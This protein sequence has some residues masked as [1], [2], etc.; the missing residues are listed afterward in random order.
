MKVDTSNLTKKT[1]FVMS[2]NIFGGITGY[3]TLFFIFRLVGRGAWGILGA[4]TAFIGLLTIFSDFGISATHVKK[5][6]EE[7]DV[8]EKMGTYVFIKILYS[9]IFLLISFLA[10]YLAGV[11]GFKFESIYLKEAV[12][13]T[14]LY[15]FLSSIVGIF[16]TSLRAEMKI[17]QAII[18]DFFRTIVQ[19]IALIGI[20]VWWVYNP[21][22]EKGY[23]GVLYTYGYLI[24]VFVQLI[25]LITYC[26]GYKFKKPSIRTIKSYMFF[27]IPLSLLGAVGIIQGYTDRAMLQFFWNYYEVGSYFG[28]QKIVFAVM[29]F[30]TA[31]IFVLYP[32]QTHHFSWKDR[33]K[34]ARITYD[35]ERYISLFILPLIGFGIVFSPEIL[36]IWNKSLISY[37]LVFQIL[38]IYSYLYVM[39]V[40]YSSQ[41]VSAGKP[42]E[43]LKAGVLQATLNVF[44]NAILI[45]SSIFGITLLGLKSVGAAVATCTS[46]LIGFSIIRY[47]AYKVLGTKFNKRIFLHFIAV[48]ISSFILYFIQIYIYHFIKF[49]ELLLA[50]GIFLGIYIGILNI[51]G[52]LKKDELLMI[53][54][55]FLV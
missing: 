51:T 24:G 25:L 26:R 38:L 29:T 42:K 13:I 39:N 7:G 28:I 47:R 35:A 1:A 31:V 46:Y 43:N 41:L 48:I 12:I 55:K 19:D 54:K 9:I 16:K 27:S 44:L 2:Y 4:A 40:P 17:S 8:E 30:G 22:I 33:D 11:L 37:S 50:G 23:V 34:F 52:E 32:A 10:I 21:Y 3:I 53:I 15:Y 20:S 18:P 14:I 49:Y 6:S 36:N 5:I 45:P